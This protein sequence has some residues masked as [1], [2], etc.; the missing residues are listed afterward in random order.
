MKRY[1]L[2]VDKFLRNDVLPELGLKDYTLDNI[3]DI[4]EYIF[5]EIEGPLCNA[6]EDG[7]ELKESDKELLRLAT[8]VI[9]EI[10]TRS[11]WE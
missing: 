9:T 6:E 2:E 8:K 7:V 10:T 4:V 1:S 11:D 3:D 5:S